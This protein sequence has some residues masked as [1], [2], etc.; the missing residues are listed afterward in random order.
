MKSYENA[1]KKYMERVP[2][3]YRERDEAVIRRFILFMISYYKKGLASP[4]YE[5]FIA[6]GKSLTKVNIEEI[7][8]GLF[9]HEDSNN[10]AESEQV[11]LSTIA[12][13]M[14]EYITKISDMILQ[15][16]KEFHFSVNEISV[17]NGNRKNTEKS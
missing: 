8:N 5:T 1:L 14:K 4:L 13:E 15:L 7:I 6:K 3:E 2:E 12:K 17:N 11:M 16:Y 10:Y 9:H